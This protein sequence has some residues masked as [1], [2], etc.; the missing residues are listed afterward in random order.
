MGKKHPARGELVKRERKRKKS[1]KKGWLWPH[2]QT[3]FD[4]EWKGSVRRDKDAE[5]ERNQTEDFSEIWKWHSYKGIMLFVRDDAHKE[6]VLGFWWVKQEAIRKI[7]FPPHLLPTAS[8][9]GSWQGRSNIATIWSQKVNV[10][11]LT[12]NYICQPVMLDMI[13][14]NS[15]GLCCLIGRCWWWRS[16]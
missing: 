7:G 2:D 5:E 8:G 3:G 12:G 4:L 14:C 11:N 10:D 9:L 13:S 15:C 1:T 6:R 16:M